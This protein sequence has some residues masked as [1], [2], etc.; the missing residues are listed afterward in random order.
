MLNEVDTYKQRMGQLE[1]AMKAAGIPLP[2]PPPGYAPPGVATGEHQTPGQQKQ[3]NPI[4]VSSGF[5]PAPSGPLEGPQR[6]GQPEA[7]GEAQ[8]WGIVAA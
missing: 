2:P 3:R 6:R 8:V 5:I 1:D 4:Q 7:P